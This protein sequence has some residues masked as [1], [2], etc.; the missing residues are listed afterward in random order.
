MA[1][2]A[3]GVLVKL[4]R[5]EGKTEEECRADECP[6]IGADGWCD[7]N[8]MMHDAAD[9][10]EAAEKQIAVMGLDITMLRNTISADKGVMLERISYLEKHQTKEAEWIEPEELSERCKGKA[11]CSG[12]KEAV[13]SIELTNE[14]IRVRNNKTR[15]CPNCGAMMTV[16]AANDGKKGDG[17][18][19]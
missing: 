13:S 3:N 5:C 2:L 15:F 17:K 1:K 18:D 11:I 12:C 10:L 9:A 4:L 8:R 19:G 14:Y 7:E 16:H 6:Y